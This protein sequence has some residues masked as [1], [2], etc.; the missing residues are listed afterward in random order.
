M[1]ALVTGGAGF[2]GSHLVH[3]L[4]HEG[5]QVLVLDDL[6]TGFAANLP[7]DV[8][9]LQGDVADPVLLDRAVAGCSLV[10]HLAAV[11][12]VQD[13]LLRPLDVHRTN[14]TGTL[15]LLDAAARGGVGRLVFSSSAA[16]YGDT[17]GDAAREDMKPNPLSHY[18]VQKLACEHYC[19]MYQ[20]L[21]GLDTVCL[22]FFNVFGPRQSV[23][24]P[25]TG[26][27]AKFLG[28]VL[29]GSAPLIYGDGGQTRDFCHVSDVVA[30]TMAAAVRPAREVAGGVFNIGTGTSVSVLDLAAEFQRLFPDLPKPR[31]EPARAG[32]IRASR[33]DIAQ[34][35]KHLGYA[36]VVTLADGLAGLV[37]ATR[38]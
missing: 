32:E 16:V 21:R 11:S 31:T 26:V 24:S 2:I 5:W 13:S 17:G 14:L 34:A 10:F 6:S 36:P 19:E 28:A 18:A 15:S 38:G 30:A 9:F 35:R 20:R 29:S 1:R 3:A 22:R 23:V 33:A 12:S 37:A 7:P 4:C 8:E 27:I 25:Y